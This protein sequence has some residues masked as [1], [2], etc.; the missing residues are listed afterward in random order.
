MVPSYKESPISIQESNSLRSRFKDLIAEVNKL[1]VMIVDF[2]KELDS[3]RARL[4]LAENALK[5][6]DSLLKKQH[7]FEAR[8][9]VLEEACSK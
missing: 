8:I 3:L 2:P 6:Q 1:R 9:K 7:D 4:E 5:A